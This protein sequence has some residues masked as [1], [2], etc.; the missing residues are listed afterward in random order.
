MFTTTQEPFNHH[1]RKI[2]RVA[3]QQNTI[4]LCCYCQ[5]HLI[6]CSCRQLRLHQNSVSA[7]FFAYLDQAT[8][9]MCVK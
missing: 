7:D 3:C 8:P 6:V 2:L 1:W 5:N 9:Y 4:L